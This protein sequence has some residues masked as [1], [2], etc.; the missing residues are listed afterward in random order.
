MSDAPDNTP[1][2]PPAPVAPS[3]RPQDDTPAMRQFRTFKNQYPD[4]VLFFRMGDFY[5]MFYDDA[6]LAHKV[7]GVTLTQRSE[8]IPMAGVPYHSAEGYL[9]RM[10]QAGHRVAVCEQMEDP[11]AAKGVIRREVARVITPGTI[12]D[13]SLLEE[14]RENPL[15]AIYFHVAREKTAPP[16]ASVAWAELSTGSFFVATF[17]ADQLADELARIAPRELLYVETADGRPPTRVKE[18]AQALSATVAGRPGWHFRQAE[19][20]EA[21][22]KQFRVASLAGFGFED[23]DPALAPASAVVHYLI[24]TQ[25]PGLSHET[26]GPVKSGLANSPMGGHRPRGASRHVALRPAQPH[27]HDAVHDQTASQPDGASATSLEH[28]RHR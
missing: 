23:D 27:R 2:S 22:C 17:S 5:E 7:L 11:A 8:G 3:L 20:V 25:S 12:T 28:R 10:I 14:G 9:R 16:Q 18:V 1:P 15:A 4:C 13:E 26:R 6:R 24:E 21:L 19:A